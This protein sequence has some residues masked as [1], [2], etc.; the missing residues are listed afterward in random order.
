MKIKKELYELIDRPNPIDMVEYKRNKE[1][2]RKNEKKQFRSEIR[3]KEKMYFSSLTRDASQYQAKSMQQK[4]MAKYQY[5]QGNIQKRD[6]PKYQYQKNYVYSNSG[7]NKLKGNGI[8]WKV[9]SI[10]MSVC[11][12]LYGI[13]Y[14]FCGIA[15]FVNDYKITITFV[16][17]GIIIC[18][19]LLYK[20]SWTERKKFS[21]KII[22][23][24]IGFTIL[25]FGCIILF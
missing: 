11:N 20:K 24:L 1:T 14:I 2:I 17:S 15:M 9:F 25:L 23:F 4:N 8:I 10:F 3:Q 13:T 18:P 16:C 6:A 7:S 21:N 22:R 19:F 5:Q 12:W